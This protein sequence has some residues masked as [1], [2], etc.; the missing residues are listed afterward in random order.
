MKETLVITDVTQMPNGDQVC[1]VGI[2]AK[3]QCIRPVCE[4]GFLKRYLY[5]AKNRVI[6]RHGARTEFDLSIAESTPPHVEDMRCNPAHIVGKGKCAED[7]WEAT[8]Q[9]SS[10]GTVRDIYGGLLEGD[11]WVLPGAKTRSIGTLSGA[12]I[13]GFTLSSGS[14]K[15]RLEFT[16]ASGTE[17][18]RPVSD[19][20]LW[21]KS[22]SLVKKQGRTLEQAAHELLSQFQAVDRLYL[23]LGLARPWN[24]KC[25]LQ[26]TGVHTFPDYLEGKCFADI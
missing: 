25:W 14:V 20:T 8:L 16:D 9:V 23:R 2:D 12:R 26:V 17:F 18:F 7:E 13:T 11:A 3:N 4:G 5:D 21:D 15:P 24:G 22:Y 6:V 10:F 19:L 1:V